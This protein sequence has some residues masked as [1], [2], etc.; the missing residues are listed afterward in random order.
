MKITTS[1]VTN[2][3]FK[4][5]KVKIRTGINKGLRNTV[6]DITRDAIQLSPKLTG[7]NARSIM[8]EFGPGG[9]IAKREMEAAIFST[10]GYGGY[11]ETG[12]FKMRAQPYFKPA[13]DLNIHK[14]PNRIKVE[15]R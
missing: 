2:L 9:E 8:F 3:K 6:I 11:L 5:V 12:T 1:F 15:L 14:L 13:L 7:N 10:S 4:E